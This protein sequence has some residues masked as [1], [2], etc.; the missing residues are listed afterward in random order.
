MHIKLQFTI[1]HPILN[2][3][4]NYKQHDDLQSKTY[5]SH[6]IVHAMEEIETLPLGDCRSWFVLFKVQLCE[7]DEVQG[8]GRCLEKIPQLNDAPVARIFKTPLMSKLW[9]VA[10]LMDL[11]SNRCEQFL[12][13]TCQWWSTRENTK[14]WRESWWILKKCQS[15]KWKKVRELWNF[16]V[17]IWRKWLVLI[18]NSYN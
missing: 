17:W 1:S 11:S 7:T 18:E 14:R 4:K 15:A 3:I 12:H 8:Y 16:S 13:T 10:I 9:T 6:I 5:K 2:Q